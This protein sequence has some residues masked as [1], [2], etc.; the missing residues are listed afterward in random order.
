MRANAVDCEED[1]V[2]RLKAGDIDARHQ[3][4]DR[5]VR[6]LTAVC[7]RYVTDDDDVADVLQE[8]FLKI[9]LSASKFKSRG[10]GS[11]KAW[12][13]RIAVNESLKCLKRTES[14]S[15]CDINSDI[16]DEQDTPETDNVPSDVIFDFIRQ[17]PAGYR[18]VFNLYVIE[19]LSHKEIAKELGIKA[20][21]SASQFHRAKLLLAQ[22]IKNYQSH[23]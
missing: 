13:T 1:L 10:Q 23:L 17:L 22:Q 21:T 11:F 6:Y 18:T 5:F 7:S 3:V 2:A 4:Y 14:F 20:D 19:G 9:F 16:A 8:T 15:L 12:I